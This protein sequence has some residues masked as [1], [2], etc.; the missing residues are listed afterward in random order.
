MQNAV[1]QAAGVANQDYVDA[2]QLAAAGGVFQ[3]QQQRNLDD[4]YS[5]FQEARNY[6]REQLGLVGQSLGIPMGTQ[7][8]STQGRGNMASGALGGAASGAAIGSVIPGLGTGIGA[9]IGAGMGALGS[10]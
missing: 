9:G 7:T 2:G 6:P 1:G 3:G 8:T 10:K 4:A 5:R